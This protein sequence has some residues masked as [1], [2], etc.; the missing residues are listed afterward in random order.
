MTGL[1][2]PVRTNLLAAT[3]SASA[4]RTLLSVEDLRVHFDTDAGVVRAVDGVTWSVQQGETLGIVG[5]S[6]SGK[7][8]SALAIMGLLPTPPARFPSGRIVFGGRNLLELDDASMRRIKGN[9]IA[10]VYQDPLTSMNPMIQVGHQIAEVIRAHQRVGRGAADRWAVELLAE[11]GIPN[12]KRRA[13]EYPHQFSGGMRQRAMIAMALALD[14]VLLLADE[15][16][17][18][19]D[20]TVQAQIMDLLAKLQ[21]DRGTAIVLITHDLGLV[22]GHAHRVMVMY[23]GREAEVG[24]AAEIFYAPSHAYTYGLLSSLTRLDRRRVNALNP[25]PGQPPSL[26]RVPPGCPFHPRCA[27][28][29][30]VCRAEEPPFVAHGASGHLS[31]CHHSEAVAAKAAEAPVA[32]GEPFGARPRAGEGAR[33]AGAEK[34]A[35]SGPG[36][37]PLLEVADLI[38]WF[39][40]TSGAVFKRRIGDVRAVDGVSFSV[41]EG[42]TLAV[43]G[44]SGCGKSTMARTIL[45]LLEPTSGTIS[46]EGRDITMVGPDELRG[47][48]RQMQ[49]VFQ[50]PYASLNPRMT[51][52]TILSQP[53]RIHK[54]DQDDINALLERV[55]LSPEHGDRYPHEF[56]GGQRQRVGIARAIAL[57]PK[58]VVCDE[59][60]SSLDVSV[61]AQVLNLLER[62]QDQLGLTYLFIAHDLGV[63][64]HIADR[65]AV[66]YLG[67]IVE[68]ATRDDLFD[69]PA[70]PYTQ[71]LIS[72]VPIP[73]PRAE[74]DR[75]RIPLTGDVPSPANPPSG[76][77]FRTR[78]PKAAHDLS[79]AER[80]RCHDERPELVDRGHGHPV[81]CHYAEV[82]SPTTGP[83]RDQMLTH[84]R[85]GDPP[86]GQQDTVDPRQQ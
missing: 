76:C 84:R 56:S 70:H 55:G 86:A 16:T 24:T 9:E 22:A 39:P 31:A 50:D 58:L 1:E 18:A 5:E 73:D 4:P 74:Q 3:S 79:E 20:V 32:T 75:R 77:R 80:R 43:V 83:C 30:D 71:A 8:V 52:R 48:R 44:E 17:T 69:R 59:P 72:S 49:I 85:L 64:R 37:A 29:T 7:S 41:R 10:M 54:V 46:F 34:D 61:Q 82:E 63:V 12:A 66:M 42:E 21:Q 6:G 51:V 36:R 62:L 35:A 14:P 13:G 27:F 19:L 67:A 60:V 28:A 11:V 15:P 65:V 40:Q 26:I 81:A 78:C 25:I 68:L 2:R 33:S 57:G 45:R 47:L 53:Y 38:K 23:A